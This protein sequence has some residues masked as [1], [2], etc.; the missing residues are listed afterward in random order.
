MQWLHPPTTKIYEALGA[1][2]DGRVVVL[3]NS[4]KV[5]SSSRNKFYSVNYDP[6]TQS[7]M[8]NDNASFFQGYL[9]YPAIAF[10]MVV[11]EIEYTPSIAGILKGISWKDLN[12]KFKNDFAEAVEHVLKNKTLEER[13]MIELEVQNIEAQLRVKHYNILGK[14]VK[15]PVGY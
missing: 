9:G 3:G 14:K 1:V 15:P 7:I 6:G 2:A 13:K 11:G 10:L 5:Y 12:Q 4:A 8:M